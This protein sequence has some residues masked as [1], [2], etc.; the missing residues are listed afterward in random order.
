MLNTYD[1]LLTCFQF[2]FI[3]NEIATKNMSS[4]VK[5][6]ASS[7]KS[8]AELEIEM[9]ELCI[10]ICTDYGDMERVNKIEVELEG[11]KA[12]LKETEAETETEAEIAVEAETKTEE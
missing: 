11:L 12:K 6:E 3:Q 10:Q 4:E 5:Q 7:G 9:L 2:I 1:Y 8:E